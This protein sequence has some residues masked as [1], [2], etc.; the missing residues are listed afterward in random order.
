[1][2]ATFNKTKSAPPMREPSARFALGRSELSADATARHFR[3]FHM[4]DDCGDVGS[5]EFVSRR[6]QHHNEQHEE[7]DRRS[8]DEPFCNGI[9]TKVYECCPSEVSASTA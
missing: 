6:G 7:E 9:L 3:N 8:D 5:E 4:V 1:A 2:A